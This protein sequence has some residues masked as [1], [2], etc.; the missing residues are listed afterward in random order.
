MAS[1]ELKIN[2][3]KAAS[4]Q[5]V[6]HERVSGRPDYRPYSDEELVSTVISS[7]CWSGITP[8]YQFDD[9]TVTFFQQIAIADSRGFTDHSGL[10]IEPDEAERVF[11]KDVAANLKTNHHGNVVLYPQ[12]TDNPDDPQNV[13]VHHVWQVIV[14]SGC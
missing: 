13:N 12:P 8:Q 1:Q 4:R 10:I 3:E 14:Q 7:S 6:E 5:M 2:G 11:G 9:D